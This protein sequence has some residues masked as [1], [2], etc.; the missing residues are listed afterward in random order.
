MSGTTAVSTSG[1]LSYPSI[2][3]S[4]KTNNQ[5]AQLMIEKKGLSYLDLEERLTELLF[6][7]MHT[8]LDKAKL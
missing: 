6:K 8:G 1:T 7:N 3:E 2:Q 5:F 4:T